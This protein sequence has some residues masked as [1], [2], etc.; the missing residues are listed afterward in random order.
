MTSISTKSAFAKAGQPSRQADLVDLFV[1]LMPR[2]RKECI[3]SLVLNVLLTWKSSL[4][5]LRKG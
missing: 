3:L 5:G 2:L 4:R 1:I